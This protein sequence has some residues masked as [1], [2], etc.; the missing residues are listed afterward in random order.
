MAQEAQARVE[1]TVMTFVEDLD[2]THLRGME[3]AMHE[4]AAKCCADTNASMADV[5]GCVSRCETPRTNT[6][7]FVQNELNRFQESLS[8]C[9][10]SCQEQ[11]KDKVTPNTSESEITGFRKEFEACA[12]KCCDN[13]LARLPNIRKKIDETIKAGKF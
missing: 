5:Q 9:V 13:D 6:Q 10:M 8:R 2:R 7:Q 11:I 12:I 4:C 1:K 3:R